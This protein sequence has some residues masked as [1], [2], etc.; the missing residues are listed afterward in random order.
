VAKTICLTLSALLEAP[1]LGLELELAE[2]ELELELE[3]VF[4]LVLELELEH[5]AIATRPAATTV[6]LSQVAGRRLK[7]FTKPVVSDPS[8]ARHTGVRRAG[9]RQMA[10]REP[11]STH[12][13][14]APLGS[15]A[16]SVLRG[17]RT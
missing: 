14:N 3:L 4:E 10:R 8:D 11:N 7:M 13:L 2:L 16:D 1:T 17:S 6:T 9:E 12:L 5:P 15:R